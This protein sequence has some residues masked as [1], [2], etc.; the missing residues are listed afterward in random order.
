[1]TVL[2]MPPYPTEAPKQDR[3]GSVS[4]AVRRA[5]PWASRRPLRHPLLEV[6]EQ[7]RC[8]GLLAVAFI[9]RNRLSVRGERLTVE[10]ER[11][12][13]A[14]VPAPAPAELRRDLGVVAEVAV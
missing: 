1:M 7:L 11:L 8:S 6:L 5:P 12:R 10:A 9:E 14:P 4:P 2:P 13:G 3:M